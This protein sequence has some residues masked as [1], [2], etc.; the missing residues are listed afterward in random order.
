MDLVFAEVTAGFHRQH[1]GRIDQ[2][3]SFKTSAVDTSQ[4][5]VRVEGPTAPS[6]PTRIARF[7]ILEHLGEG[8]FGTVYKARDPQL[9]RD[10]A[11]KIP[12][13]G[14]LS[15]KDER[16]RFLREARA[17]AGL[18]HPNICPVYEVGSTPDGRDYIVMAY[19]EGKSLSKVIQS[20]AAINSRQIAT[21]IRKLALALTEAH[22]K[23]VVHRDLKPANIMINR[24]GEPV[25]MDFGLT[26]RDNAGDAQISHSGQIMGTPAYMSPEQDSGDSKRVGPGAISQAKGARR[27]E[28]NRP[29][30]VRD[31]NDLTIHCLGSHAQ[32]IHHGRRQQT[33][34]PQVRPHR[35]SIVRR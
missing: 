27:A 34:R 20:G 25:I 3:S 24:K 30:R 7:Q 31:W 1:S 16:D 4:G 28:I 21:V 11:I 5:P 12:R 9:D 22:A 17:A 14:A 23:G 33:S 29:L 6:S 2:D 10:V 26:R 8:A 15:S 35:L 32:W 19:I 13:A 18:H